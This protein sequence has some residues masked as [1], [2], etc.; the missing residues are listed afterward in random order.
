[1]KKELSHKARV[2]KKEIFSN[3]KILGVLVP[4]W[5]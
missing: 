4:W 2:T 5:Q 3:K 1:M